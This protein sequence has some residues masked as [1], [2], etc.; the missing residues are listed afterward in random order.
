M[1]DFCPAPEAVSLA[2]SGLL[3]EGGIG[4]YPDAEVLGRHYGREVRRWMLVGKVEH[5]VECF[6]PGINRPPSSGVGRVLILGKRV[7]VAEKIPEGVEQV[8]IHPERGIHEPELPSTLQ[9]IFLPEY[10]SLGSNAFW[11]KEARCQ[12]V[13]LK[14]VLGVGQDIRKAW[15]EGLIEAE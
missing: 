8:W 5:R 11:E 7:A 9:T 4:I 2:P 6:S 15:P 12:G 10:D 1:K 13:R 3:K 14:T